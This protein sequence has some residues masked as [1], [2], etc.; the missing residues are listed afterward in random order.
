MKLE[1]GKADCQMPY[2]FYC[3]C[4]GLDCLIFR[5]IMDGGWYEFSLN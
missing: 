2:L 3:M 4:D 1:L 5:G